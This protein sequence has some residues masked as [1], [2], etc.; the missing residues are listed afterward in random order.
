MIPTMKRT[1]K[2]L[3]KALCCSEETD[4]RITRSEVPDYWCNDGGLMRRFA[5]YVPIWR[6]QT[7]ESSEKMS[8]KLA[9]GI[10]GTPWRGQMNLCLRTEPANQAG[11]KSTPA[12]R[13]KPVGLFFFFFFGSQFNFPLTEYSTL[14]THLSPCKLFPI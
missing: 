8:I 3:S 13:D 5:P 1:P 11:L 2:V 6:E 12:L 4:S 7:P 10:A 14:G 9:N